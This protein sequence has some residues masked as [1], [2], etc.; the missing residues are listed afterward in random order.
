MM[1]FT[2][3]WEGIPVIANVS[4]PAASLTGGLHGWVPFFWEV[5]TTISLHVLALNV[6][7][8]IPVTLQGLFIAQ[9]LQERL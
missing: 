1:F 2:G 5:Q 3:K 6:H 8:H 9:P 4:F 7:L